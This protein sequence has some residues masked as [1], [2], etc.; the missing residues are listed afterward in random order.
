MSN[1]IRI[2]QC[3]IVKDEEANI[4][5]ALSWGKDIMYEQIVVDTGSTDRTVEIAEEMGAKVFHFEWINDFSAAKNYALDQA[6]GNWIAFLDAD[7]YFSD[8]DA[9][10]IPSIIAQM[11]KVTPASRRPVIIRTPLA[12]L[13]DVGGVDSM[14]VQ[15][16]L[17]RRMSKLCYHNQIHESLDE[18]GLDGRVFYAK[19]MLTIFHTG[20]TQEAFQGKNK[21]ERNTAILEQAV[22]KNPENYNAWIYLG[23]SYVQKKQFDAAQEAYHRVFENVEKVRGEELKE[24]FFANFLQFKCSSCHCESQEEALDIYNK[25]RDFNCVSPDAEYWMGKWLSDNGNVQEGAW[26]LE[27]ALIVL[28][29]SRENALLTIPGGIAKV[30]QELFEAKRSLNQL[31]EAVRYGTLCLRAEPFDQGTLT[32]LLQLFG[33]EQGDART[34]EASLGFLS[35]LYDLSRAKDKF[36]L[37]KISEEAHFH[38]LENCLSALLS[39]DEKAFL[40][41]DLKKMGKI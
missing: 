22:A 13:N 39:Q 14:A 5:R 6:K 26:H 30:Y 17:F 38:A 10:K 2:S 8:E 34:A 25:A 28:E 40:Q 36:F 24:N 12:N 18:T 23:H 27:Q 7:E 16:R 37:V 9:R 15:D 11:E 33:N 31:Q 35:K 1:K 19:D 41:E 20:Y 32:G 29:G 4:R 3:M 21:A